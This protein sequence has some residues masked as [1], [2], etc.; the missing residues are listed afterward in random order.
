[1]LLI[2]LMQKMKR[3]MHEIPIYVNFTCKNAPKPVRRKNPSTF[4]MVNVRSAGLDLKELYEIVLVLTLMYGAETLV[5]RME[6]RHKLDVREINFSWNICEVIRSD[7]WNNEEIRRRVG[8]REKMS[9]GVE[10]R[11]LNWFGRLE[12][13]TGERFS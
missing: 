13:M 10:R 4:E 3:D 12:R 6:E 8:T 2:S 1:M 7:R 9:D 5:M 11:V